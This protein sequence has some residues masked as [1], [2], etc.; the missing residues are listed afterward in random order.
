M[1]GTGNLFTKEAHCSYV[2]DGIALDDILK[3]KDFAIRF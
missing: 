1:E 3:E 2:G